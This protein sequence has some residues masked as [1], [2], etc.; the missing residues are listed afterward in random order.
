MCPKVLRLLAESQ[1]HT[2]KH[3]L[4]ERVARLGVK[5]RTEIP[6]YFRGRDAD[7][8]RGPDGPRALVGDHLVMF[9]QRRCRDIV[10]KLPGP[11]AASPHPRD[12]G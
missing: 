4:G 11:A 7:L 3:L 2:G 12:I 8:N 10:Q 9:P 1:P 6:G 5:A